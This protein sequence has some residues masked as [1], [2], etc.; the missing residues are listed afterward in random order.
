MACSGRDRTVG[1]DARRRRLGDLAA[2]EQ[3]A[4]VRRIKCVELR[5]VGAR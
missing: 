3:L 4:A 1:D 5:V 2:R